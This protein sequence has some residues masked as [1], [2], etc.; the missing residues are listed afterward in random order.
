MNFAQMEEINRFNMLPGSFWEIYS[1]G[2]WCFGLLEHMFY[3]LLNIVKD[4][5]R[6]KQIFERACSLS[7]K[8]EIE[9]EK[10]DEISFITMNIRSLITLQPPVGDGI[11]EKLKDYLENDEDAVECANVLIGKVLIQ[12]TEKIK[13]FKNE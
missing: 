1:L 9:E 7:E 5:G 11:V 2:E 13:N 6:A 12:I 3:G 8:L 10:K 4:A